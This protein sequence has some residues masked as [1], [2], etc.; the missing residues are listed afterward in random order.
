MRT[1]FAG[2]AWAAVFPEPDLAKLPKARCRGRYLGAF[3]VGLFPALSIDHSQSRPD[4]IT[5]N[6][7]GLLFSVINDLFRYRGKYLRLK[8]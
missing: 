5:R 4:C 3:A 8:L 7:T 1:V 6:D 2:S